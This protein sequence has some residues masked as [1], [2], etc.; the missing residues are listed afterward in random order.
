VLV[1]GYPA[2]RL[3]R[4]LL[5][6]RFMRQL[7]RRLRLDQFQ[8]LAIALGEVAIAVETTLFESAQGM[9]GALFVH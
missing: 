8:W 9:D 7:P 5:S 3:L 1:T 6:L 4:Q 2:I